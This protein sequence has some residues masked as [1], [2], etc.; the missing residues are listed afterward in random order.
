MVVLVV[1]GV[2]VVQVG[3]LESL[4]VDGERG[5]KEGEL[6]K[7]E[8]GDGEGGKDA[9]LLQRRQ[10]DH[11]AEQEQPDFLEQEQRHVPADA[12]QADSDALR[13]RVGHGRANDLVGND[14]NI[15]D[16]NRENHEGE[17]LPGAQQLVLNAQDRAK[18]DGHRQAARDR[19]D[20]AHADSPL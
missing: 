6:Q 17:T 14:E 1:M 7:V 18:S 5:D 3:E 15:F 4:N 13:H 2:Q 8:H 16:T 19:G 20:R 10:R 11:R 9:K 12:A